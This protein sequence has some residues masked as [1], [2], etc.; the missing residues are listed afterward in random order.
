MT[1][2]RHLGMNGDSGMRGPSA[3]IAGCLVIFQNGHA[4]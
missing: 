1:T 2:G 4:R 3:Q